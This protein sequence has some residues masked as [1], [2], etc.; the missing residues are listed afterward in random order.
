MDRLLIPWRWRVTF[1]LERKR[2][3]LHHMIG[4]RQAAKTNEERGLHAEFNDLRFGEVLA[5]L[6]VNAVVDTK[7]VG[8]QQFAVVNR[9]LLSLGQIF[10]VGRMFQ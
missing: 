6:V 3:F 7:M 4:R 9:R 1:A 8:G 5:Q 2:K 10:G